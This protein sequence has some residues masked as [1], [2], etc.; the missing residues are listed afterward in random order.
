[1]PAGDA[2][3]DADDLLRAGL[4]LGLNKDRPRVD[5]AKVLQRS[6]QGRETL[7]VVGRRITHHITITDGVVGQLT[8]QG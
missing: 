5:G 7:L 2:G 1:M 6:F 8:A 4:Q 3:A